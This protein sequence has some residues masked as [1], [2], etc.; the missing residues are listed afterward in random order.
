M[1]CAMCMPDLCQVHVTF[2]ELYSSGVA[3]VCEMCTYASMCFMSV[4]NQLHVL[5]GF[6]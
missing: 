2:M 1:I 5:L 6:A 4:S 3:P